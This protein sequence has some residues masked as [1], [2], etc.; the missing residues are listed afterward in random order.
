MTG[1]CTFSHFVHVHGTNPEHFISYLAQESQKLDIVKI[2]SIC[3]EMGYLLRG[4]LMEFCNRFTLHYIELMG[5]MGRTAAEEIH[6]D[7]TRRL[8][9]WSSR[10]NVINTLLYQINCDPN[11]KEW[12]EGR[13]LQLYLE[14]AADNLDEIGIVASEGKKALE[15]AYEREE[16]QY[17]EGYGGMYEEA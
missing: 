3:T 7:Y 6:K 2:R 4:T 9:D 1:S 12:V 5:T 17:Q 8:K 16:L 13:R 11:H 10:A 15:A 14:A